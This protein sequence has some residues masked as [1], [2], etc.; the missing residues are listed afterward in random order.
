MIT[1]ALRLYGEDSSCAWRV[2]AKPTETADF[3]VASGV[4]NVKG[5]VPTETWAHYVHATIDLLARVGRRGFAFNVLSLSS[6]PVRRRPDLYY[7]DA[8]EMLWHCMRRYGRS[9]ALLQ[10]YGLYEFTMIVRRM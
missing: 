1:E 7:A 2:G 3:A 8:S 4:F 5:D 9:V 10:D 6:D